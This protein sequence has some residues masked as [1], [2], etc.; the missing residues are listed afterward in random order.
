MCF[1][2]TFTILNYCLGIFYFYIRLGGFRAIGRDK[3]EP[4]KRKISHSFFFILL[5]MQF[6]QSIVYVSLIINI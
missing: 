1:R 2:S 6:T 5:L 3:S 4:V